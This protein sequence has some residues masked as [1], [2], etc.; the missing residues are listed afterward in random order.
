M[1]EIDRTRATATL[2]RSSPLFV[3]AVGFLLG[4]LVALAVVPDR[5]VK[6]TRTTAGAAGSAPG[7]SAA[8]GRTAADG[9]DAGAAVDAAVAGAPGGGSSAAGGPTRAGGGSAGG[10]RTGPTVPQAPGLEP[11]AQ[12]G[13]TAQKIHLGIGLPDISV[14]AALGPGYDQGDI[15]AHVESV[16]A[17]W[18]RDKKVPVAGRDIEVSYR[19]YNI[20]SQDEQRAACVGFGQDDKVFAVVAIH[21][22]GIG[23]SECVTSEYRMPLVTAD[24]PFDVSYR[25]GWP[26]LFTMAMSSSRVLRNFVAWGDQ[27]GRFKGRRIGVYYPN[28]PLYAPDVQAF[29]IKRLR[30]LGYQVVSEVTTDLQGAQTGGPNDSVAVQRFRTARVD[31]AILLVSPVA[32]TNFFNQAQLQGYRP[33]YL[34][35][36]LAFSTTTTATKTYPPDYFD[37]MVGVT[38]QRFGESPAGIPPTPEAKECLAEFKAATGKTVDRDARE[39]EYIA[40]N[41]ACDELRVVMAA[42]QWAGRNLT[43]ARFVAG[44]ETLKNARMGIHGDVTFATNKHDG[45]SAYR[46]LLWKKGCKCWVAQ[47]AFKPLAAE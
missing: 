33:M 2:R 17:A 25:R 42:L 26:Y 32:K 10:G 11:R 24:G 36:D 45:V 27:T 46:E 13:V 34:E 7:E 28:D 35:N 15:R 44:L 40:G 4:V 38:G 37:G 3:L 39:A 29:V 9:T 1:V 47:G 18:R 23:A 6:T 16:L 43:P 22:F 31:T 14:I 12:R 8:D 20:L 19:T 5:S 41:Q 21:D 30:A